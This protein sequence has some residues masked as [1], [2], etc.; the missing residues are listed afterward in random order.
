MNLG[1]TNKQEKVIQDIHEQDPKITILTG[2]KRAGKTYMAILCFIAH[3]QSFRDQGLDFIIGGATISTIQR[4]VLNE[5]E[6]MG[7][8]TKLNKS[9]C[10][11]LAGNNVYCLGGDNA[12]SWKM[13]RGFTAYGAYLNEGTALHESFIREVFTRCS[14]QGARIFI[15]TNPENPNHMI[16]KEFIDK[17]GELIEGTNRPNI[18]AYH[19]TMD[20]N[21][22]LSEEYKQSIKQSIPP[23]YRYDR[24]ILGRW[25]GVE[26]MVYKQY[27]SKR[28]IK[29]IEPTY[30]N[31]YVFGVDWGF[32]HRGAIVVLGISGQQYH[33]VEV[34]AKDN[35]LI[36]D[37]V[38]EGHYIKEKY[39]NY[40]FYCDTAMPAYIEQFE[41]EGLN[42]Q[43][44][45]KSIIAGVE[46]VNRLLYQEK[47]FFDPSVKDEI[48]GELFS[49][50]WNDK[51]Q[52]PMDK[53]DDVMDALRY[54]VYT[55]YKLNEDADERL[56]HEDQVRLLQM[57]GVL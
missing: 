33:V 52:R 17:S 34:I 7:I 29:A 27:D 47:L 16:K 23:G 37:W 57:R 40:P 24:D 55:D 18:L 9:N 20:D 3:V 8:P 49:Y 1:W 13:A 43:Y 44:G 26:G 35:L 54:G 50:V 14:G 53:N 22:I 10:F 36:D 28:H 15:D 48:E 42:A 5:M 32:R 6:R 12:S 4:N 38:T 11:Q 45:N 56:S 39:G 19:F 31:R 51:T 41:R 21:D 2:G 25:V 30:I 46:Y